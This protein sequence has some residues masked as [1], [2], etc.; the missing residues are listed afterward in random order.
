MNSQGTNGLFD[1]NFGKEIHADSFIHRDVVM[2]VGDGVQFDA[3]P[4]ARLPGSGVRPLDIRLEARIFVQQMQC[5]D[6]GP[7]GPR[8]SF[9][10]AVWLQTAPPDQ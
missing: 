5:D 2:R 3:G 6:A 4:R 10:M 1:R 8:H 9:H 7:L